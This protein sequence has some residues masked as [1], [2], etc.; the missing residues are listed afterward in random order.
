MSGHYV[1]LAFMI[2]FLI[3][4]RGFNQQNS[5]WFSSLHGLGLFI[6]GFTI[7]RIADKYGPKQML[8]TSHLIA[9]FYTLLVWLV[10]SVSPMVAF[11]A[12]FITGFAQISDN[13]GYSNMCLLLCPTLDKSTYIAVTNVGVN[14]LTV[15]LPIIFGK[16]LDMG[17]L[18]FNSMFTIIVIMMGTALIYIA[19]IIENPK[20]FVEMKAAAQK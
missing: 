7:T 19:T 2:A 10:P 11:A 3:A 15:P 16:L 14:L 1:M 18:N 5:G 4:E 13:V 8:I 17:I 12:F 9:L 6:G 20:A